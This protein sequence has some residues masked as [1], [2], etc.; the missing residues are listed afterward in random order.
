MIR[1][2]LKILCLKALSEGKKSGYALMKYIEEQM[3]HKPSSGSI[4]PLLD[5]LKKEG[6]VV[7]KQEGRKKMYGLTA[8]GKKLE[9]EIEETKEDMMCKFME[10][11]RMMSALTGEDM[12]ACE[13]VLTQVH[14]G[15]LPFKEY[16]PELTKLREQLFKIHKDAKKNKTQVKKILSEA[17]QKLRKL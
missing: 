16:N 3:G 4:Y 7:M 6:L 12:S 5:Q 9:S 8:R 2:H 13:R 10:G 17:T 15:E 11:F 14:K 1:G